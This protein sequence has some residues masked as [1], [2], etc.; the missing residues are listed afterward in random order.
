[1]PLPPLNLHRYKISYIEVK[2]LQQCCFMNIL[3][4]PLASGFHF[5]PLYFSSSSSVL[6]LH[7]LGL[8]LELSWVYRKQ[9]QLIVRHWKAWADL[10][11]RVMNNEEKAHCELQ[12]E[13]FEVQGLL[14]AAT[15][16]GSLKL[17]M[18]KVDESFSITS[19]SWMSET[20]N[21]GKLNAPQLEHRNLCNFT[22]LS[23]NISHLTDMLH[24][25]SSMRR[26]WHVQTRK[27]A[28]AH[29]KRTS[30]RSKM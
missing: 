2:C 18:L 28:P 16:T 21:E 13:F 9:S 12:N 22:S 6:D 17:E 5:L 10:E 14:A 7:L 30:N 25:F 19:G 1:M 20:K 24:Y 23:F 29:W 11:L 15:N 26:V 4:L 3:M 8:S 27:C